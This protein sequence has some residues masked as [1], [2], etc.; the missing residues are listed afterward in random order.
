MTTETAVLVFLGNA[1]LFWLWSSSLVPWV[2][3]ILRE[4]RGRCP[5][6]GHGREPIT[7]EGMR[8]SS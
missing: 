7:H 4:T 6:C 1:V 5:H 8:K 3:E 2:R